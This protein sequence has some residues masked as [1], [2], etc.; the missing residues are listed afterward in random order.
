MT[1]DEAREI[2]LND[3]TGNIAQRMDALEVAENVLGEGYT[4]EQLWKWAEG[5]DNES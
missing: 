2:I 5:N 4:I 3:P 1:E